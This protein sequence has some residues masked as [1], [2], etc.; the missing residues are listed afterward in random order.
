MIGYRLAKHTY[1]VYLKSNNASKGYMFVYWKSLG[2]RWGLAITLLSQMDSIHFY[3]FSLRGFY[4]E[5]KVIN[6][7]KQSFQRELSNDQD[8]S[9]RKNRNSEKKN[10][11]VIRVRK[12]VD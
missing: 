1:L 11:F 12:H 10:I 9:T 2:G 6:S 5:H 3:M 8:A 4:F 7:L